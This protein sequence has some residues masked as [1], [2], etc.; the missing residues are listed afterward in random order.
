MTS[1]EKSI[2]Q[3]RH[4]DENPQNWKRD[5]E[6]IHRDTR[7]NVPSS[8]LSG[9]LFAWSC[10]PLYR[11]SAVSL[12]NDLLLCFDANESQSLSSKWLSPSL[13]AA[14]T[15]CSLPAITSNSQPQVADLLPKQRWVHKR[16]KTL[17]DTRR[18]QAGSR[19]Q[20]QWECA[21]DRS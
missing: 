20:R 18:I 19:R 9:H 13:Q 7:K 11:S 5:K 3:R 4:G 17:K 8:K 1:R 14:T 12:H 2:V 15:E 6:N 10:S 21:L 16:T